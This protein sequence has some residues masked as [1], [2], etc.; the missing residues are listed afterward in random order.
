MGDTKSNQNSLSQG[1][2]TN[3]FSYALLGDYLGRS[4]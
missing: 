4:D 3:T 2:K 1:E